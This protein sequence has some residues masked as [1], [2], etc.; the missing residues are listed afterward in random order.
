MRDLVGSD[1]SMKMKAFE[2]DGRPVRGACA[3][4]LVRIGIAERT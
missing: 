1:D 2:P 3:L 4:Q